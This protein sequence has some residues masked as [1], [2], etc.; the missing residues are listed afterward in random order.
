MAFR[1]I[2]SVMCCVMGTVL[3]VA[4][5]QPQNQ[6]N[7]TP[8]LSTARPGRAIITLYIDCS[9]FTGSYPAERVLRVGESSSPIHIL[10][11]AIGDGGP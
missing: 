11:P 2:V 6:P 1:I 5:G 7:E 4:S 10:D 8:D 9:G 3:S